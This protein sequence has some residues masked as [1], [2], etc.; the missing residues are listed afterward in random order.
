MVG[1][2]TPLE[3]FP[4][5]V[6]GTD[7]IAK[8]RYLDRAFGELENDRMWCRAW[9]YAGPSSDV[10][11]VGDFLRF[12][13][14]NESILV[15]RAEQGAGGLRA[16][17]NVCQH[18]GSQVVI[19]RDCGSTRRFVCP[20]H[21]WTYDL[22]G[23][24]VHAPDREDFPQGIPH[25]LRI[26]AVQVD[27]W[28]GLVFVNMD[29]DAEPLGDFLGASGEHLLPY[30]FAANYYLAID[31]TFE[32]GCNWKAGVDAFNEVYHVQG[33][34]PE[35]LD[36]TDDVDCPVDLLGKHSRFLFT[37]L[38]PSP[39]WTDELAQARGLRDRW[40]LSDYVKSFV[41]EAGL[42]PD[43]Y[44]D[45]RRL[46]P[47]MIEQ[48]KKLAEQ[49]GLDVSQLNDDQIFMDVHYQFF[50]NITFNISVQHFWLFRARPHP[51]GDPHRM[52]WDFQ[53]FR[54]KPKDAPAPERPEHTS[55]V[56]GD[57][58]EKEIDPVL[59]QDGN[60]AAPIQSGMRSR[61]F[62]GLHLAHQE[63]RIRHFHAVLDEYLA[64]E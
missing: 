18:R 62:R 5:P 19:G 55:H 58:A 57:G 17:Y 23:R 12:D 47:A 61:G 54:R 64:R 2:G 4:E 38:R 31:Q 48:T 50:P 33:I 41:K 52:L 30:D 32:W 9:L 29:P 59:Q 11:R 28:N 27:E 20:Y 8:E 36:F 13:I 56:W 39:R 10:S 44:D 45:H 40:A 46:R 24:L 37:V 3:K 22:E 15:V 51:T 26:P 34:H 42:D 1:S 43:E 63:R 21:L 49:F 7:P 60:Q 16:F 6:H 14:A 53:E 25:D 35:L